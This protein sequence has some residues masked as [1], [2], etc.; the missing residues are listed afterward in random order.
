[1]FRAGDIKPENFAFGDTARGA[2]SLKLLD[3]GL[4]RS[5]KG[6]KGIQKRAGSP[7]YVAPEVLT[8]KTYDQNC[9]A[10]SMGVLA[11]FTMTGRVPF[12]GTSRRKVFDKIIHGTY[13]KKLL[14]TASDSAVDFID[15][16]LVVD[17]RQRM[18]I[19]EASRHDWLQDHGAAA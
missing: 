7:Y 1:M 17:P 5:F 8:S 15:R 9:D 3:F 19:E 4:S 10:W 18:S 13:C 14:Q 16:L 11:Y 2:N 12:T 6:G